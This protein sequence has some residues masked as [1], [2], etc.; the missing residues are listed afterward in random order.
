MMPSQACR[1]QWHGADVGCPVIKQ[2]GLSSCFSSECLVSGYVRAIMSFSGP[3]LSW[4]KR[5]C[6]LHFSSSLDSLK[7]T[8]FI[9]YH[10]IHFF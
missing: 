9:V 6:F 3:L 7:V 1:G 2:R 4:V 10:V 5:A 8:F